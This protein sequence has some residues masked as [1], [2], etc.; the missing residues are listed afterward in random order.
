MRSTSLRFAYVVLPLLVAAA[1]CAADGLNPPALVG[2][3]SAADEHDASTSARL[4]P[5]SDSGGIDSSTPPASAYDAGGY[6]DADAGDGGFDAG[7]AAPSTGKPCVL[8][9]Q[10]FT[11]TCGICGSQE[12]VCLPPDGG[13]PGGGTVSVYSPCV[14]EV[15]GGCATGTSKIEACGKCG[16]RMFTCNKSCAWQGTACTGEPVGA[17]NASSLDFTIAGCSTGEYRTR[18]CDDTCVWGNFSSCGPLLFQLTIPSSTGATASAVYPLR[19]A[20]SG[21]RLSGTCSSYT[22]LT[23]TPDFPEMFVEVINPTGQTATV[24]AWNAQAAG[25][26]IIDTVMAA[27]DRTAPP[28]TDA[29]R[30]QCTVGIGDYCPYGVPCPSTQWAGLTGTTAITLAPHASVILWFASK[31]EPWSTQPSEGDVKLVVRTDQLL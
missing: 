6:A 14:N 15:D 18:E 29:E 17:C 2:D 1:A 5:S 19:A 16:T 24:S 4:P 27:Y 28:S 30:K 11:R 26:P 25:G 9:N 23:A 3:P 13:G 22:Y 20:H 12:A 31:Y 10:I 21:K 8:L 7:L